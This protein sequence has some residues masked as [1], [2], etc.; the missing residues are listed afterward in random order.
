MTKKPK[1]KS[2]SRSKLILMTEEKFQDI[3]WR[4]GEETYNFLNNR[5]G[6]ELNKIKDEL[7]VFDYVYLV[8]CILR[9]IHI[10]KFLEFYDILNAQGF[11][12]NIRKLLSGYEAKIINEIERVK[13]NNK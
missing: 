9:N 10:S 8:D 12:L 2:Q 3:S 6:E 13:R 11:S 5:L 1:Q 4:I 7:H